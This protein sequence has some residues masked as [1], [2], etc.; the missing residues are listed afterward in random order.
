MSYKHGT[1]SPSVA[2]HVGLTGDGSTDARTETGREGTNAD[3]D[4][5]VNVNDP[6]SVD[7]VTPG[8]VDVNDTGNVEGNVKENGNVKVNGNVEQGH[9]HDSC[10]FQELRRRPP[11]SIAMT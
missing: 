7:G 10:S 8:S 2:W 4:D 11:R 6:G 9:G 1:H 5:N 3:V